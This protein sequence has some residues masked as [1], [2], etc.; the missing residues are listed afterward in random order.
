MFV[1]SAHPRSHRVRKQPAAPRVLVVDDEPQ[2]C[3]MVASMLREEGFSVVTAGS[4]P[5]AIALSRSHVGFD[6]LLTDVSMPGM[7]GPTLVE[8][9]R[10]AEP[11]LPVIFMSGNCDGASLRSLAPIRFLAKPF[12]LDNLLR[13]VRSAAKR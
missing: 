12:S 4:G 11:D 5:D 6:L 7:D 10:A 8:E 13:T 1:K 3:S 9:L 2:V